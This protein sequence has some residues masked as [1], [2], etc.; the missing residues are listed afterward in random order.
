MRFFFFSLHAI[1]DEMFL[2][3]TLQRQLLALRYTSPGETVSR[4]SN[5]IFFFNCYVFNESHAELF[6][7]ASHRSQ[8]IA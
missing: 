8:P 6:N 5:W 3:Q 1:K 4:H 7:V 2:R